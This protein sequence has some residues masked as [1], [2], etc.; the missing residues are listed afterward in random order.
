M[1][2]SDIM[3]SAHPIVWTQVVGNVVSPIKSSPFIGYSRVIEVVCARKNA[4][5]L[6]RETPGY[7][8]MF[9]VVGGPTRIEK[10]IDI[11]VEKHSSL[12]IG[13]ASGSD[14]DSTLQYPWLV[15][16]PNAMTDPNILTIRTCL[17]GAG[18]VI[19]YRVRVEHWVESMRK[20]GMSHFRVLEQEQELGKK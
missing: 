18:Y 2:I 4:P 14:L 11:P 12:R 9:S 3:N 1:E 5:D 10:I 17:G 6:V 19:R 15:K 16:I 8:Q 20:N 13:Y 7:F